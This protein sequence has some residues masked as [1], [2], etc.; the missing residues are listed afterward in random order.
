MLMIRVLIVGL[1]MV[2][3]LSSAAHAQMREI[4]TIRDIDVD[5]SAASV[6]EAQQRA[7][8]SAR[9]KGAYRLIDRLTLPEDR[10]GKITPGMIDVATANRLAAA[11]DVEEET[12]GGGRYV[13]KIAVVYNPVM[14]RTFLEERS[15]PYVD[16]SAPRAVVFPVSNRFDSFTWASAWPDESQ[17]NLAPFVVSR[18]TGISTD[19]DWFELRPDVDASS[20]RRAIKARLTGGTGAFRVDLISV[21]AAGETELGSTQTVA[22][23]EEAAM[24]AADAMDAVWKDQS[25]VRSTTRT[26]ARSTI[27]F[28][29]LVEWN[30]LRTAIARSP[31][32][33][34]FA[35]EGLSKE[36]AVVKFVYAGDEQRLVSNLRERGITLDPDMMG[37]VMT[38]AVSQFPDTE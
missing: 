24:A 27:F 38:S 21:T 34:D 9:I 30:T 22:T 5:E 36:G 10:R 16:S 35:V 13:G 31:L 25:I 6:I 1:T 26:P 18:S 4:Y 3:G 23:M 17:G 33:F 29:S 28:T 11:V 7:F 12:R 8:A 2:L 32:I 19:S 15:I 37:W 14:V 20:A